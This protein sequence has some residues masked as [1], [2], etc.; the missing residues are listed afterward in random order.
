MMPLRM[1]VPVWPLLAFVLL[2]GQAQPPS[3]QLVEI[4]RGKHWVWYMDKD[5]FAKHQADVEKFY[6]YA[7]EAFDRITSS[8]GLSPEREVY[9]LYIHAKGGFAFATGDIGEVHAVTGKAEPGI[10]VVYD[11]FFNEVHG[12]RGYWGYVLT[13]HEMTNLLT[14]QIVSGGWPVHWWADHQSPFPAMTAVQVE[15]ALAPE[16]AIHHDAQFKG[17]GLYQMFKSLKDY[18]GWVMFHRAFAYLRED[19]VEFGR[20]GPNPGPVLTNYVAAY[21]SMGAGETL[22]SYMQGPV[23]GYDANTVLEIW[24]ARSALLAGGSQ[25]AWAAYRSGDYAGALKLLGQ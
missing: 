3:E 8:W 24:R 17:D 10:G 1:C 7:D 19:K 12:L 16:A 18:Y 21:L 11:A 25:E 6:S 15:Y 5:L 4:H 13:A 23:P 22:E 20:L 9:A 14:G 2:F